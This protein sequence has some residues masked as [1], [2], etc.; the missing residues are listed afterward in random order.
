M[1]S[2]KFICFL[3]ISSIF[4]IATLMPECVV[5]ETCQQCFKNLCGP[6]CSSS[7]SACKNCQ[8]IDFKPKCRTPC[9]GFRGTLV[10]PPCR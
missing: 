4:L 3:A 2:Q 6:P 7:C 5:A 9:H 1:A 10:I 8:D